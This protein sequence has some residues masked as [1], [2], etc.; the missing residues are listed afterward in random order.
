MNVALFGFMGVGKSVVGRILAEK[1]GFTFVDLDEEIVKRKGKPISKIFEEEGEDIFREIEKSITHEITN[2]NNQVIAC[3][4]G[5]VINPENLCRLRNS[6]TLILLTAEPE[7]I[8]KRV[9]SDGD[10]RPLLTVQNRLE[11][12]QTLLKIRHP[13]YIHAADFIIDT[14]GKTPIQVTKE[15]LPIIPELRENDNYCSEG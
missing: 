7:T 1:L 11:H 2:R 13:H 15:I 14:T 3:G 8:L 4:G 9:E 5:T 12:I 10:T 6:S